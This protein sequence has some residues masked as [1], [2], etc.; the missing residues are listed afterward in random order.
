MVLADTDRTDTGLAAVA[1]HRALGR[2]GVDVR[3]VALGPG[4]LGGLDAL[5]PVLG[6]SRG[7]MASRLQLRREQGWADVVLAH[8]AP[9]ASV[10]VRAAQRGGPPVRAVGVV[11]DPALA[12]PGD[13]PVIVAERPEVS[14]RQRDAARA[15][16]G[17]E[18]GAAVLWWAAGP[19]VHGLDRVADRAADLGATVV[20]GDGAS[21]AGP[22]GVDGEVALAAADVALHPGPPAVEVPQDLLTAATA[23]LALLAPGGAGL[24]EVLDA[25]TGAV[26]GARSGVPSDLDA[27]LTADLDARLTADVTAAGLAD[28]LAALGDAAQ[29]RRRGSEARRR[30]LA[31]HGWQAHGPRW[32]AA[33]AA[34]AA[35]AR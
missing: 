21:G 23:G 8:G 11:D 19:A 17:I 5:L 10:A 1:L 16:L 3:T 31:A 9:A 7:S 18:P 4:R 30:I 35:S 32:A 22:D 27:R 25:T 2:C 13:L 26:L 28:G 14:R 29:R 33:L 12:M 24:A 34:V 20:G 6:H 15:R